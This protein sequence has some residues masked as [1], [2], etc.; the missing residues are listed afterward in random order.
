MV[1]ECKTPVY[2][3]ER[4]GVLGSGTLMSCGTTMAG[5][6]NST[7][8]SS[9]P[10]LLFLFLLTGGVSDSWTC[11]RDAGFSGGWTG[12]NGGAAGC[13]VSVLDSTAGGRDLCGSAAAYSCT[14][15]L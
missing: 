13:W 7:L 5:M 14:F 6:G 10:H 4:V 9:D 2:V 11:G 12:W 1:H 3:P 15:S 8:S